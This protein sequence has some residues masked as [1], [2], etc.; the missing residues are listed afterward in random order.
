M[1]GPLKPSYRDLMG[2][3]G[4]GAYVS[5]STGGAHHPAVVLMQWVRGSYVKNWGWATI[6]LVLQ[7]REVVVQL[8]HHCCQPSWPK[9]EA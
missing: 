1:M 6:P 2:F 3:D 8:L 7:W 9:I 4:L 5:R